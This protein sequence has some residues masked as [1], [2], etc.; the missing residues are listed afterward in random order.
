MV[1]VSTAV[2][3]QLDRANVVVAY[4]G[5]DP[6]EFHPGRA[7]HFRARIGVP[8]DVALVGM[9]G[10]ID[11]WKG[12]EVLLDATP[13]LQQ[14]RPGLQVVIA[15]P[16][17]AGKEGYAE[18]LGARAAGMA[19][20][21]WLGPRSD[22]AELIADLDVLVAPSTEPEPFGLTLVEAL[23]SGVVVVATAAGG[24]LEILGTDALGGPGGPGGSEGQ[25][26][27]DGPGGRLVPPS[28]PVRL[29]EGVLALLPAGP[30]S[31]NARR[32]RPVRHPA[33]PSGDLPAVFGAA[34]SGKR[35][36]LG[37]ATPGRRRSVSS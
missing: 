12:V 11:T 33:A 37:R 9:A 34:F 8:D 20:V 13:E 30:S 27:P 17:V 1:A 24:H 25:G 23:A 26:G 15:G 6:D 5:I 16:P 29:A 2:A 4:D 3:D 14:Q 18:R 22:V 36:R 7:G 19:G 35:R 10:R 32:Q 21:H 28:D 31:T